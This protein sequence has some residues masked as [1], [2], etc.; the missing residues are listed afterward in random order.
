[1]DLRVQGIGRDDMR[2][3]LPV[4]QFGR[5]R[6]SDESAAAGDEIID[7]QTAPSPLEKLRNAAPASFAHIDQRL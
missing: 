7:V 6:A 4:Q 2:A 1:M 3:G 5:D